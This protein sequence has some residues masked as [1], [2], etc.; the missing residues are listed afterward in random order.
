M[1]DELDY[2]DDLADDAVLRAEVVRIARTV[3]VREALRSALRIVRD[4]KAPAQAQSNA[5]RTLLTLGGLLDH[6]DREAEVDKDPSEMD[7]A[8]LQAAVRKAQRNIDGLR[9]QRAAPRAKRKAPG[10]FD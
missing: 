8:E 7:G 9:E 4:P 5:Q 10:V 6:R 1:T 2:L 3:G